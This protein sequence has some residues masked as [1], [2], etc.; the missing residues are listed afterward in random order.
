MRN[1][2]Y[3]FL[4]IRL[5]STRAE[6]QPLEQCGSRDGFNFLALSGSRWR[7]NA[8]AAN[9]APPKLLPLLLLLLRMADW[10]TCSSRAVESLE[11]LQKLQKLLENIQAR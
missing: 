5:D 11:E 4:I 9:K 3:N 2:F 10:P 6:L 7:L 1:T 8:S